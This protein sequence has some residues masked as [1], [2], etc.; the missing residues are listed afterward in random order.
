MDDARTTQDADWSERS[1]VATR[2]GLEAIREAHAQRW[3]GAKPAAPST[4]RPVLRT[5]TKKTA[6]TGRRRARGDAG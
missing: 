2:E 3:S 4:K 1:R 5:S 6:A